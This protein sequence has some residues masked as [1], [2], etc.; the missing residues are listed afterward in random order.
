MKRFL[1]SAERNK[2]LI[3]I[4]LKGFC[5]GTADIVPG[6]SGGTMAFVLG[7]Y[8]R[9]LK[10]IRAFDMTWARLLF[11]FDVA[12]MLRHID[13]SFLLP[14]CVGGVLA[15]VFF[16]RVVSLPNLIHQE[17]TL[18]Y[19]LFFGL[20]SGS[21]IILFR[22]SGRAQGRSGFCFFAGLLFGYVIV[23]MAPASTPEASWFV[24]LSGVLAVTAMLLPGISGSFVLLL[25]KK[26]AYIMQA[27]A[28]FQLGVLVPFLLGMIVGVLSFSRL[29]LCL[30]RHYWQETVYF[31]LGILLASLWL[32]WPF[33]HRSYE[34]VRGKQRLVAQHPYMPAVDDGDWI[35]ALAIIALGVGAVLALQHAARRRGANPSV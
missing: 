4:M 21:I 15:L 31:M 25:L 20:I 10:A 13:M 18:V 35:K 23:N 7:I 14:L 29:M 30:L 11:R 12:G 6:V 17:P 26:Y 9:L 34:W 28:T 8:E 2:A 16:T 1:P 24:F 3:T 27:V 32:L 19:A 22:D 33:Q 5:V